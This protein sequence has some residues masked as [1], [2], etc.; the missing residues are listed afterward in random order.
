[1]AEAPEMASL[2]TNDGFSPL[3]L[4]AMTGSAPTVRA[5]L[6]P[7]A[8]GTP[9]PASFSG[10]AG[11]TALHVAASVSKEIAQAILGWEPQGLTLLTRADS[12]GRTPLHFA[13]LYGKLDIVEL[14]LQHCHASSLELASISDNSG[15]SPLHIAAMVAET[16]IIDELTKGWPNYYELVDDKG[17][18]FLHRA[19][20]HGQETVVRHICR[21]D[22]FTMLL[23]ATDSQG[24]TPL[25][26]AAES[27]NPGIASL[28]LAT[29]SVDMGITNKDG[30]TAGDLARRARA[31]GLRRYFLN[32][33]TVLYNC[34]RWSRAPFTL[35][36]DLG[37]QVDREKDKIAR[38]KKEEENDNIAPAEEEEEE[39]DNIG[40]A[41]AIASVLIATVAFAAA[42]TVPGGF[43]ADDRA[44][45][46][47]AVLGSSF[48][49][50]AFAVSDTIAFLCS[51]VATCFLIYS[52]DA[53]RIPRSKHSW[54]RRWTSGLVQAGAQFLIAAFAF[55]LVLGVAVN[56]WLIV[57]VYVACLAS[58]LI[59]F[60]SAWV[61]LNFGV[62]KAIWRR[63]GWRGLVNIH[64]RPSTLPEFF[65][66]FT[67]SVLYKAL[68][69]PLFA[70]LISA[71]FVAA[72]VLSIALP[73][74]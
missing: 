3:Y 42:F 40:E 66:L 21:N 44:R 47:T 29:T 60:P 55:Q 18:N 19:V 71:M 16:G 34:L 50:R 70:L 27:G 10:P 25:H 31:I 14:F 43:I 72:I 52:G 67:D 11:R 57:F 28:I 1:M 64:E 32:P 15:S 17:R 68:R 56:R 23:N 53:R 59:C 9:S 12:S 39:K 8:E 35:E 36:G 54:Y 24:N 45:A 65:H 74:Y 26:L 62:G 61:P 38:A 30:L 37:L 6:R 73:N 48:A 22:M 20:E 58:V 13:A 51:I 63:A 7:S 2:A 33:Q 49:F 4:A 46:G 5:L 69:R 41:R